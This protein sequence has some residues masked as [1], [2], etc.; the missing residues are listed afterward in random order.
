M[1]G[2]LNL[3][4]QMLLPKGYDKGLEPM[5]RDLERRWQAEQA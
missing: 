1:M 2:H 3:A 5:V 4:F